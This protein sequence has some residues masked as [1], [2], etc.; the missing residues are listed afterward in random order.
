M[1]R[2]NVTIVLVLRAKFIEHTDKTLIT[3]LRNVGGLMKRTVAC[4][5]LLVAVAALFSCFVQ[6]SHADIIH[7]NVIGNS[8]WFTNI[9]EG[10][11][12]GD[13]LPLYGQPI[14]VADQLIFSPTA[15]FSATST[16]GGPANQT[17]GK[18]T[19]TVE[20]KPGAFIDALSFDEVGLTLLNAPF[21]GDAFTSVLA[22]AEVKVLEI[23]HVGVV[24]PATSHF[25]NFAPDSSFLHSAD[26]SGPSFATAWVGS[27][28]VPM[29]VDATKVLV[30][31][32]NHLYAA[33]VGVGTG[34]LIDKK[35]FN[36]TVTPSGQPHTV[37]EPATVAMGLV[38]LG[39][40]LVRRQS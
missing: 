3:H 25:F 18:L 24:S 7:S 28:L 35:G 12:T 5:S 10:S 34:A 27:L 32:D 30:T 22:F 37:P 40:L 29:P 36:V 15:S 17:D 23:N 21:G 1:L 20:A 38:C 16:S 13:T 19:F 9:S 39:G 26:A 8:V 11:P 6:Q 2:T 33:T 4:R 14:S 31:V